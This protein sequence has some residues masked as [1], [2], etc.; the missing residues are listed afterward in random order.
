MSAISLKPWDALPPLAPGRAGTR[1]PTLSP[2]RSDGTGLDVTRLEFPV[3][4]SDRATSGIAGYLYSE[5]VQS[6]RP[7]QLLLHGGTY[8]HRYWDLPATNGSD[9]SYA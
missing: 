1:P 9:Y 7:L 8:D 6:E 3:I 2:E 4:L 5:D